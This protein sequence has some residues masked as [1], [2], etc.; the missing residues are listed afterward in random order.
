MPR[1][2][3]RS[4]RPR[5]GAKRSRRP[6]YTTWGSAKFL[7]NKAVR[8]VQ[9]LKGLVNSELYKFDSGATSSGVTTT[10]VVLHCTNLGNGDGEGQRTGNSILAKS[11]SLRGTMTVDTAG[12]TTNARLCVIRDKQQIGDS[13]PSWLDVFE[14]ATPYS[15]LKR[16]TVGRFEILYNK[17]VT[18]V[19]AGDAAWNFVINI[20]MQSHIRYNG[21]GGGDIQKNGLF[22]MY[23][24]DRSTGYPNLNYATRLSYHD[25]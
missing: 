16:E 13:S 25:N 3:K 9:Y 14:S 17:Q 21:T 6:A 5:R 19:P 2:A 10:P 4:S 1:Y 15:F 24:S 11:L 18:L 20:P 7:A 23:C 8:G 22:V 12:A